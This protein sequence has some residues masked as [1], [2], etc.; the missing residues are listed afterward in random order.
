MQVCEERMWFVLRGWIQK[1]CMYEN[2]KI[3]FLV[4]KSYLFA[5]AGSDI[6]DFVCGYIQF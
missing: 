6:A 3:A 1:Q 2:K 4:M 5:E